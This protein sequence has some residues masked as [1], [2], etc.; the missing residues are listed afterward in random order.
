MNKFVF[1][2]TALIALVATP[3][4]ANAAGWTGLATPVRGSVPCDAGGV[5]GKVGE[6]TAF[7]TVGGGTSAMSTTGGVGAK[8]N[9]SQYA[10]TEAPP[11]QKVNSIK[12]EYS[13]LEAGF[14]RF[15]VN[16]ASNVS[17]TGTAHQLDTN[18]PSW[19]WDSQAHV[20]DSQPVCA[21]WTPAGGW[22]TY[23]PSIM[24]DQRADATGGDAGDQHVAP[25]AAPISNNNN[26]TAP[27]SSTS[28]LSGGTTNGAYSSSSVLPAGAG[29]YK[30]MAVVT[31]TSDGK[32][33]V[34]NATVTNDTLELAFT[35]TTS[36]K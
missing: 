16:L 36:A 3:A 25:P 1:A 29:S 32:A 5:V 34:D 21:L 27:P 9:G 18:D 14:A 33:C 2:W 19:W 11:A 7:V 28:Q 20:R 8:W 4:L 23:T 26:L 22:V 30:V 24:T 6:L 13:R 12:H 15:L 35:F 31:F 10:H 17:Q